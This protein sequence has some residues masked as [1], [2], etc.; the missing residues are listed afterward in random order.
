VCERRG[1]LAGQLGD[2]LA[3]EFAVPGVEVLAAERVGELEDLLDVVP[4]S[5]G[6]TKGVVVTHVGKRVPRGGGPTQASFE[7]P[8]EA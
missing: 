5:L 2:E 8:R 6:V 1:T 7:R 3:D 4:E